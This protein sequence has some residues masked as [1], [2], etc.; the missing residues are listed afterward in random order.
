M[1]WACM[2]ASVLAG[3]FW[4]ALI[5]VS[6]ANCLTPTSI[7]TNQA[8]VASLGTRAIFQSFEGFFDLPACP[9]SGAAWAAPEA[10]RW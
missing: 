4:K 6:L 8:F 10:E 1:T 7:L 9:N 3:P 5:L 2:A